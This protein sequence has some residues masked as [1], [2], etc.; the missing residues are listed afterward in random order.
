MLV[1]SRKSMKEFDITILTDNRYVSPIH[2]DQYIQNVLDEDRLV[3]EALMRKGLK[4]HRTNWDNPNFDW[5]ST[6]YIIFR[7]TWDYFERF[8]EFDIWLNKVSEQTKL[9]NPGNLIRWSLDKHYLKDLEQKNI[10]IPPTIFIEPK[11]N[12][13]LKSVFD[14][15][16]WNEAIVKPAIS[17]AARH[18]YRLSAENISNY[19]EIYYKLIQEEAML[20]QEFQNNVISKGEVSFVVFGGKFSHAILK[21]AKPGDFRVQDDFGGTL[22]DYNPSKEEIEFA[23]KTAMSCSPV[24]IY[25]RVDAIW[26]NENKLC[27]S[28]LE[29]IEPE[30]WFRK[31]NESSNK[32]AE[33]IL[34]HIGT[35]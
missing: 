30:L 1:R 13:T 12:R 32:M 8:A 4:V 5:G 7:S 20:L 10:S 35:V 26:D 27:I 19:E 25:A 9:I 6:A 18:T 14:E 3:Q 17:G 31:N 16:G 29:L 23:E 28:E 15:S 11:D 21:K 33:A 24:P 22:H 34:K 2:I